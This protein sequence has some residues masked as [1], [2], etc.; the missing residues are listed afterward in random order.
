VVATRKKVER[1]E[2]KKAVLFKRKEEGIRE[3]DEM[4]LRRKRSRGGIRRE[5]LLQASG[6]VRTTKEQCWAEGS[7]PN[8]GKK[9]AVGQGRSCQEEWR[10]YNLAN[11]I[12]KEIWGVKLLAQSFLSSSLPGCA[13]KQRPLREKPGGSLEEGTTR[14]QPIQ[15]RRNTSR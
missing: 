2:K 15:K 12:G 5:N 13:Q 10:I 3:R 8:G 1:I 4:S 7:T 9:E 14:P 11:Y 6:R